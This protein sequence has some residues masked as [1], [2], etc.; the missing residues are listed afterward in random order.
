MDRSLECRVSDV[1]VEKLTLDGYLD[2]TKSFLDKPVWRG[3]GIDCPTSWG[4]TALSGNII[5]RDIDILDVVR[6]VL[7]GRDYLTFENVK[8]LRTSQGN[9]YY[10]NRDPSTLA[11]GD[12][13]N[14]WAP[15]LQGFTFLV[16]WCCHE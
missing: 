12:P 8:I 13:S 5:F 15:F 9:A 1:I 4:C 3:I 7:T 2:A 14:D 16:P 10:M 6:G 11:D